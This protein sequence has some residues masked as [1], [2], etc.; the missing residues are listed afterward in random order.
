MFDPTEMHLHNTVHHGQAETGS[1]TGLLGRKKRLKNPL[2]HFGRNP[3]ARIA[4]AEP[5]ESPGPSANSIVG[6]GVGDFDARGGDGEPAALG[7][8]VAGVQAQVEQDLIDLPHVGL[9][10]RQI[11]RH[12][13][14]DG[15]PRIDG[16]VQDGDSFCDGRIQIDRRQ[17]N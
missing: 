15:D 8:S 17:I 16:A 4:N 12:D 11:G 10:A 1:L 9:D 6:V 7:H 3:D 2:P 14:V 13:Y 5:D